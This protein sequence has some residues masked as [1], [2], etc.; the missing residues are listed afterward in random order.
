ML[1][2]NKK[3]DAHYEE[4]PNP[5]PYALLLALPLIFISPWWL[6]A[7]ESARLLNAPLYTQLG[8]I[9]IYKLW[10]G[11]LG[12]TEECEVEGLWSIECR[13]W[14]GIRCSMPYH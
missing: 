1:S 11:W 10:I 4:E 7:L 8:A 6:I 5:T 13:A 12:R 3:K 14:V 2:W 9:V